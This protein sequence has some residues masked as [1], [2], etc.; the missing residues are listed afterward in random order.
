[1]TY[2]YQAPPVSSIM[3]CWFYLQNT[4]TDGDCFACPS[5]GPCPDIVI[6]DGTALTISR[7]KSL[8]KTNEDLETWTAC[9]GARPYR[10]VDPCYL[11][12]RNEDQEPKHNTYHGSDDEWADAKCRKHFLHYSRRTGGTFCVFCPHGINVGFHLLLTSEG[13]KDMYYALRRYWPSAPRFV[14][15]DFACACKAYMNA[16]TRKHDG[17]F[18]S[19]TWYVDS[20][21]SKNHTCDAKNH[22]VFNR[23]VSELLT[24]KS[25]IAE[26]ANSRLKLLKVSLR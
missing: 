17:W 10:H 5:C 8:S 20:F 7:D 25:T 24:I 3:D 13:R 9:Y 18:D 6:C 26:V 19:T 16:P 2:T 12:G 14:I 1:M 15:Y 23:D 11:D 21:H 4:I 22:L